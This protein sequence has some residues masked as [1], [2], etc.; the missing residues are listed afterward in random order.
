ML[1]MQTTELAEQLDAVVISLP[2]SAARLAAFRQRCGSAAHWIGLMPG[3]DGMQLQADELLGR[4]LISRSAL[5]WPRGQLGCALS[6][7]RCLLR[8]I[9]NQRPL[10][11]FEDD[12][13]LAPDW[14]NQLSQLLNEAPPH[15]QL[16]L[17][18]WNLD[19][20]LQLQWHGG[21]SMSALFRPRFPSPSDLEATLQTPLPRQW[22]R[23]EKGLGLA[24]YVVSPQGAAEILAWAL[25][26][27][28][29]PIQANELPERPCFSLDGQLNSLYPQ[30]SAWACMPPLVLGAN[31]KPASLTS[32]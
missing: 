14:Q 11:I 8:C 30:L 16:L 17:L 23:L 5:G 7:V 26:L 29:L 2:R 19:S 9:R 12:A 25:P 24:G 4:G 32:T 13:L 18:G 31:D 15:W 3:V 22:Y 21:I 10:L 28:T 6:H 20:C 1:T 27:R